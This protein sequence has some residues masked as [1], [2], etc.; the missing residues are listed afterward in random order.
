MSVSKTGRRKG[1]YGTLVGNLDRTNNKVAQ[2]VAVLP[3]A[4]TRLRTLLRVCSG[5]CAGHWMRS[6][7]LTTSPNSNQ[8]L[9]RL[10]R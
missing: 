5:W 6:R 9:N 10:P 1:Q 3:L 8:L 4:P 7:F 2:S